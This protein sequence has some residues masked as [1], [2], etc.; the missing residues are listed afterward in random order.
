M[1][2]VLITSFARTAVDAYCRG[3]K[4]V[5]VEELAALVV[6]EAL[7]RSELSNMDITYQRLNANGGGVSLGHPLGCSGARITGTLAYELELR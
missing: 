2:K 6:K 3:L 5:S 4:T 7:N 1:N